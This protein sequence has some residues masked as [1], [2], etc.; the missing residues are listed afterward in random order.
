MKSNLKI[1]SAGSAGSEPA[2]RIAGN[3]SRCWNIVGTGAALVTVMA[4]SSGCENAGQ[5]AMSGAGIGALSGLAIGSMSGNAGKGAAVGAI[6]GG[7]GGAAIG[8]QNRRR[9]EEAARQPV[10]TPQ[11]VVVQQPM[12]APPVVTAQSSYQTGA[13]LGRLVGQWNVSGSIDGGHGVMLPVHG[14]ARATVDMNFFVRLDLQFTDPR[15]GVAVNGTSIIS[16]T[17]QRGVEMT[18]SFSSSPDVRRYRGEMDASGSVFTFNQ[19]SPAN[20]SR[21]MVMRLSPGIEWTAE[22]WDRGIRMESYTFTWIGPA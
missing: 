14:T 9:N 10:P 1:Y 17:G 5:G 8:D 3:R 18:S 21:R 11:P 7:A 20:S 13:A 19:V 15:T 2:P 4:L 16:Q 6:V 22:V 12:A